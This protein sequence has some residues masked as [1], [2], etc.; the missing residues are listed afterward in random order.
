MKPKQK[1]GW[2]RVS[3]SLR[4]ALPHTLSILVGYVL[5]GGV[6]GILL[7][8]AG[9]S[10]VWAFAM[11]LCIYAGAVQFACV[12]LLANGAPL[13]EAALLAAMINAR[14]IFY[15]IPCLKLFAPY[16]KRKWYLAFSLTDETFAILHLK[17]QQARN[18]GVDEGDFMCAV[19]F[20]HHCYWILGCV[21]GG[22]LGG[23][24]RLD[25]QGLG[26]V[27]TAIFIVLFIEQCKSAPRPSLL[28]VGVSLLCLGIFGAGV[29]LIPTLCALCLLAL[30]CNLTGKKDAPF[31]GE[32]KRG[33]L[34]GAKG[35]ARRESKRESR[36][37]SRGQE[38]GQEAEKKKMEEKRGK[39]KRAGEKR[40][41]N[42]ASKQDGAGEAE[43][44]KS[45]S[46]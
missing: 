26:F 28:G 39:E 22:V 25:M 31:E 6:F 45:E 9:F 20:L 42:R 4:A 46:H 19:A 40:R 16:P 34:E 10:T 41:E 3:T 18:S 33:S 37:D 38:R 21:L 1:G 23:L 15:A 17:A 36:L 29:F 11:G 7:A 32:S 35:E 30:C 5:M 2:S 44:G 8:Q 12:T 24:L 27:M 13:L 43:E 14:Q